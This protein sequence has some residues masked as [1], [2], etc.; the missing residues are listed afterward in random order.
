M[1]LLC[2]DTGIR[3][4][5]KQLLYGSVCRSNNND[6]GCRDLLDDN[7]DEWHQMILYNL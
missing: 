5:L 6:S 3:W 4:L 2:T 7:I 1:I